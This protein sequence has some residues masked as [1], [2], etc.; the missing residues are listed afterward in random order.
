MRTKCC[1]EHN[2]NKML[3]KRNKCSNTPNGPPS[4][5][6]K[7]MGRFRVLQFK[8]DIVNLFL[9]FQPWMI[10]PTLY[11]RLVFGGHA[12]EVTYYLRPIGY[13]LPKSGDILAPS[14]VSGFGYV[15]QSPWLM[16]Y[17]PETVPVIKTS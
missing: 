3:H 14:R 4:P 10:N 12:F 13:T 1:K 16:G 6:H 8:T 9:E 15:P 5:C 11:F 2:E 17:V 7:A